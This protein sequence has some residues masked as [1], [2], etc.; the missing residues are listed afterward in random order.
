LA[1]GFNTKTFVPVDGDS[2][3]IELWFGDEE[4]AEL[5]LEGIDPDAIGEK[6]LAAA[7]VIVHLCLPRRAGYL[8]WRFEFEETQ[9]QLERAARRRWWW[10]F[11]VTEAMAELQQARA[12][13]LAS[14][15]H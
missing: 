10:G 12:K 2:K 14:E 8:V 3:I 11:G 6:R 5:E 9:V 7:K 15:R 1:R 4:W 13:L